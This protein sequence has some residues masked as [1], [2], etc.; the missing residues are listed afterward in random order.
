MPGREAKMW[1]LG[2]EKAGETNQTWKDKL[3]MVSVLRGA[4]GALGHFKQR[5]GTT[6]G[7]G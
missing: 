4:R 1:D 3:E 5:R 6:L 2:Q 7:S